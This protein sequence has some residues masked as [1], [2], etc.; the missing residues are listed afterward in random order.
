MGIWNHRQPFAIA[1]VDPDFDT[2]LKAWVTAG[3]QTNFVYS[4]SELMEHFVKVVLPMQN[5][6]V[7]PEAPPMNLPGLPTLPAF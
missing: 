3:L 4:P 2:R 5:T 7:V 6:E 1:L